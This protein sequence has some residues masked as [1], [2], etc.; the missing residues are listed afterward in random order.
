MK[1]N[2]DLTFNNGKLNRQLTNR[3]S[4]QRLDLSSSTDGKELRL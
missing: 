3:M 2:Q 1:L 4:L